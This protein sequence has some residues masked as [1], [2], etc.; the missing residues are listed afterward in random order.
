MTACIS[1]LEKVL[2]SLNFGLHT[3]WRKAEDLHGADSGAIRPIPGHVKK[4][5]LLM[6][7]QPV[8]QAYTQYGNNIHL[9]AHL[10]L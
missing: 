3:A 6:I 2:Q 10:S 8:Y 9:R 7:Y 1:C 5:N 4:K